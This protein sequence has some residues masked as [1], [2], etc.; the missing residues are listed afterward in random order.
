MVFTEKKNITKL[1]LLVQAAKDTGLDHI[2][3]EFDYR[4]KAKN[5]L[6]KIY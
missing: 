5:Y 4:N 2:Q 1:E 6:R 3:F